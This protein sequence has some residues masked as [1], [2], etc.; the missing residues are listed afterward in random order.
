MASAYSTHRAAAIISFPVYV[1]SILPGILRRGA[2]W[3]DDRAGF[4][5]V[6]RHRPVADTLIICGVT[7]AVLG[8]LAVALSMLPP[9]PQL[10]SASVLAAWYTAVVVI[11]LRRRTPG[12]S[13]RLVGPETPRG[14]RWA[15]TSLAQRPGTRL[16]ALLLTRRLIGTLPDGAVVV[17][18]ADNDRL[19]AAYAR[20]GFTQ[21]PKRRVWHM[22]GN[23]AG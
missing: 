21:G 12:G 19:A 20:L 4:V 2:Y 11:I 16:T 3:S 10:V 8:I 6:Q 18:T 9:L 7:A 14:Q 22:M 1:I 23:G 17:A 5:I 13:A 15:V